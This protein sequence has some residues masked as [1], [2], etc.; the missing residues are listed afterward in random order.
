MR[1]ITA[2]SNTTA[3]A[4]YGKVAAQTKW[5]TYDLKLY[6]VSACVSLCSPDLRQYDRTPTAAIHSGQQMGPFCS[7]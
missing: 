6:S 2:E 7:K 4:L 5:V 1:W 3:R